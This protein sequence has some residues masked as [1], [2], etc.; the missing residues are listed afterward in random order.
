M[1]TIELERWSPVP[2]HPRK[3]EYAGQRT[4]QEVFEELRQRLDSMGYLPDEYFLLDREWANGKEIPKD[5]D[6]F[7]TTDYGGNEGVYTEVYLK[8]Y[9]D[10]KTV[11]KDFATG[12]TLGESGS[13]LDRMYL[14][15]SAITKA[16]HGDRGTYIRYL[17]RDEQPEPESMILHLNPAEQ[18]IFI[19]ALVEQRERMVEQ[20]VGVEQLLRRMTGSI[21][22]YMNEVGQRPLHL[23]DYDRAVLAIQDG[24]LDAFREIYPKAM[25]H[26]ESL[27]VESAG[28]PGPVGRKMTMILLAD[29]GPIQP[30]AY[31]TACKRAVDTADGQRISLLLEQVENHLSEPC[32]S[33]PGE[34]ILY[35]CENDYPH[36]AKE[37]IQ[38]CSSEQIAAAPPRLL[39]RAV[40]QL[41]IQT[42][43]VLVDKGA[44]PGDYAADI[45]HNL[46]GSHQEWM[47]ERLLKQGMPVAPDNYAALYACIN[48][49]ATD[50][51]KL[52]LDRGIDLDQYQAWAEKYPKK[53]GYEEVM[54]ELTDYW[55]Q[56]QTAPIRTVPL[57]AGSTDKRFCRRTAGKWWLWHKPLAISV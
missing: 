40:D 23:S 4:A 34:V 1:R 44:Q 13:D 35:A 50:I 9:E 16:F 29:A 3:S 30:E 47:A 39:R 54:E 37:L 7:C 52:L 38:Q 32:P 20:T 18:R 8:W 49:K 24:E 2:G 43:L 36:I 12:K 56:R 14:I 45:L 11:I 33:L 26:V 27:L 10:G 57:W 31:L 6:V 17:H 48:N 21:T 53:E 5:A 15:A 42:A 25:D 41:G 51:A 19:N 22:A 46:T 55:A 28:R